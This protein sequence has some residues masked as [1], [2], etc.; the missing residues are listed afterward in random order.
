[1]SRPH[2]SL[3]LAAAPLLTLLLAGCGFQPL[4]GSGGVAPALSSVQV[5][6][7]QGRTAFLIKE[8]LE[9][10]LARDPAA[11][12]RYK[13]SLTV[14]QSRAPR[15]VRV[16]NVAN[17]YDIQLSIAYTL[18]ENGTGKVVGSGFLP[19]QVSYD[20]A[21]PPYAGVAAEQNGEERAATQ[22][23]VLLRLE[24]SR[25]FAHLPGQ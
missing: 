11:P 21:D 15:G 9:D 18:V 4:Y 7:P 12:S 1:M 13:L 14:S 23:A 20:S 22:A 2:L 8:Q 5:E 16:N 3:A 25:L 19:V 17:Q 10:Q 6:V 24:L